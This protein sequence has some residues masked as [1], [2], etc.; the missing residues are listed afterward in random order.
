[1]IYKINVNDR[2]V[3]EPGIGVLMA[4]KIDEI[5]DVVNRLD[6]HV[7]RHKE[8]TQPDPLG[9]DVKNQDYNA[10]DETQRLTKE[11]NERLVKLGVSSTLQELIDAELFEASS[12][13]ETSNK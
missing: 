8:P 6:S 7:W 9:V 11:V 10:V 5:I 3:Y 1:M 13:Q 12:Y 2:P 4:E